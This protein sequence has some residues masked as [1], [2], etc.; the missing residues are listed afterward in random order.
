MKRFLALS[1][2]ISLLIGCGT[3]DGFRIEISKRF[4]INYDKIEDKETKAKVSAMAEALDSA[5]ELIHNLEI[6]NEVKDKM[7][8]NY[9]AVVN[10]ADINRDNKIKNF[11]LGGIAVGTTAGIIIGIVIGILIKKNN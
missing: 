4:G 5:G 9:E 11:N 10:T 6:Q 8:G 7:L 2:V 1:L 3:T